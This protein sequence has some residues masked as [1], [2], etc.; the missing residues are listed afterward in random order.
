VGRMYTSASKTLLVCTDR[1]FWTFPSKSHLRIPTSERERERVFKPHILD[2]WATLRRKTLGPHSSHSAFW[3]VRALRAQR[4]NSDKVVFRDPARL[5]HTIRIFV[6][7]LRCFCCSS[8]VRDHVRLRASASTHDRTE[9][10]S[11]YIKNCARPNSR[12][13][14][15]GAVTRIR[16]Y[17]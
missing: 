16:Q 2:I 6:A 5:A 4:Q 13:P 12:S 1:T 17:A 8:C 10:H 14:P 3:I 7:D 9:E 11:L 15:H